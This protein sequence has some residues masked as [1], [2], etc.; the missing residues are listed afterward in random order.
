MNDPRYYAA[1]DLGSNSFHM[2]IAQELEGSLTVIDR[3]KEMVQIARGISGDGELA[4]DAK[5]RALECLECFR[6]RL[7]EFPAS[8]VRAVGT[9]AL[10]SADNSEFLQVA[11][12]AL[13]H[14]I[15]TISGYEEARL[16]FQGVS[17]SIPQ[18]QG[19]SLVV[20]IGGGST[21][22]IIGHQQTP[23]LLE[24]LSLGCVT[25][26]QRYFSNGCTPQAM[27]S[28]YLAAC[29][30]LEVISS[31]YR[32]CG[33]DV[34]FGA[35]GTV[36]AVASYL[37][38]NS[39]YID[40]ENLA[41]L[42]L[43]VG[44]NGIA[45][46]GELAKLRREVLPAGIAILKAIFDQL[47]IDSMHVS[48]AALK[49]GLIYDIV[50]RLSEKDIRDQTIGQMSKQ[51]RVDVAQ[52]KRVS[53][54]AQALLQELELEEEYHK[55][56]KP[57]KLL[58]WA[59]MVHEIGLTISHNDYH[60][61][62]HYI[63]RHSDMAGF[64]RLEQHWLAQLLL[65]HR[66]KLP[67]TLANNLPKNLSACV[68]CLRLAILLHRK[69]Q[70]LS[71]AVHLQQNGNTITLKVENLDQHPLTQKNLKQEQEQLRALGLKLELDT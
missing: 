51:Y 70:D 22:F 17:H 18:Q 34:C 13:G 62:G 49:E 25:F 15:E 68:L 6:E 33:W 55:L 20:D 12:D 57:H 41:Q 48:D 63:L 71:L 4:E 10:R 39:A 28:A 36:K 27:Q 45:T 30:E 46:T 59:A 26:S 16:V 29:S 64:S 58:H 8:S 38:E 52:A 1:I 42:F 7:A 37:G 67:Q 24:S 66:K 31:N 35:S 5:Q 23:L 3:V 50:G 43:A 65:L 9:K 69:R 32:Q 40:R 56:I 47:D 61:H 19:Q 54:F 60:L 2:I 44:E 14:P 21:E 53:L 11:Q